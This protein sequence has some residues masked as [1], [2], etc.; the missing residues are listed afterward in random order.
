MKKLNWLKLISMICVCAMLISSV[1]TIALAADKQETPVE[2]AY[3]NI[4]F[5]DL[6][7]LQFA[8]TPGANVV[9]T[10]GEAK[11]AVALKHVGTY[12]FDENGKQVQEGGTPYDIY[13]TVS[14][15]AAQNINAVVTV[16]ATIGEKTD[17]L[18][19]SVLMYLYERLHFDDPASVSET[20]A[21]TYQALLNYAIAAD[22]LINNQ[23]GRTP[24][25]I[26]K[27]VSVSVE[28]GTL[29][30][31]NTWGMFKEGATPFANIEATVVAGE[32]EKVQWTYVQNGVPVVTD[33]INE[34]KTLVISGDITVS[35]AVVGEEVVGDKI[36]ATFEFGDNGTAS[37]NDG[38]E[39]SESKTYTEGEYTLTL[40]NLTKV[41][42]GARDQKGNSCLKLGTGSLTAEFTFTVAGDVDKVIIYVSG[43]KA[44]EASVKINGAD[45]AISAKS[46]DGVYVGIEIDTT[47][48]KTVTFATNASPDE[49]CM[50]NTIQFVDVPGASG[51]QPA[52]TEA[53]ETDAPE[54][55]APETDAPETDAPET[56]APET[57]APETDAP[58]E[59]DVPAHTCQNV[60]DECEKCTN[61]ECG[62]AVCADKCQGH[63]V[64]NETL[65]ADF[66]T[67]SKNVTSY[68]TTTTTAGWTA[69]NSQ[70]TKD[71]N[72]F[73]MNGK[74]SAIGTITSPTISDGIQK[75]SFSYTNTFSESKGVSIKIEII[76]GGQ[77]VATTNL[78]DTS[79]TQNAVEE[80]TWDL[81]A[82]GVA[83]K[84][85]F[86]IKLT[87]NCPSNS[88]SNKDRV[89]VF[90]LE[91]TTNK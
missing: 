25:E 46:N 69:T 54:T 16:T 2:I 22:E 53:P 42:G 19:Y 68:T 78:V 1:A 13:E 61:T 40:T 31:H 18:D 57:E 38:S 90:N 21:K 14:G 34:I 63:Q 24:N 85:D 66:D 82:A 87:N 76:Q 71:N 72:A 17:V 50:I 83:V 41:F 33:D 60:C 20:Q 43:Y 48:N 88:T 62:E 81:A 7:K 36:L 67:I 9:A 55:E 74:K 3:K 12:N 56:D 64:A 73:I 52:E 30:G 65:K 27:Y 45:Y 37:H 4:Y 39:I 10:T 59:P 11:D 58:V 70:F 75:L 80:F 32:G 35:A 86:T 79:V 44:N 91:W 89:S 77:V 15:W 84:G 47:T 6:I 26:D 8:V 29:D 51:E 5:G 28:N 23:Q 49:R